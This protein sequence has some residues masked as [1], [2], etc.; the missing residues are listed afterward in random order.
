MLESLVMRK[1]G[2]ALEIIPLAIRLYAT[3]PLSEAIY[4]L[5]FSCFDSVFH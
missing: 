1:V 5:E 3:P 4:Y 2:C